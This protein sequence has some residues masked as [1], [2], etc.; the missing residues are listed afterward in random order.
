MVSNVPAG[1]RNLT[2]I[3]EGYQ[4]YTTTINVPANGLKVLAPVTLSRA[5]PGV[6]G[7]PCILCVPDTNICIF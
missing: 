4:Q 3:K 7:C 5:Q 6:S 1:I 2:L